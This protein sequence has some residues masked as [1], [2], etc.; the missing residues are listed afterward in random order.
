MFTGIVEEVGRIT[1]IEQRGENRRITVSAE[2]APKELKTGD[3]VSVSGVFLTALDVK[4]GSFCADLAPETWIL[5]SF[6][7]V[8]EGTL[9]NL[10]LPMKAD[11][12][13]GGHIV[14]GQVEGVGKLIELER[15][16][17]SENW[18]THIEL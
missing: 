15:I 13:F 6:S 11:G 17:N 8:H 18:G 9:V 14:Q 5:T 1:R 12:R 2:H 10:E 16:A 3:S 4:P 7:R